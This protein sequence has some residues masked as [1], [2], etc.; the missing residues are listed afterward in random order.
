MA[1]RFSHLGLFCVVLVALPL[2]AGDIIERMVASVN[3]HLILQSDWD[4]AVCFEALASG[5]PLDQVSQAQREAILDRLIDQELLRQQSFVAELPAPPPEDVR[6]RLDE[7]RARYPGAI[8]TDAWHDLLA[9][10]GLD[11]KQLEARVATELSLMRQVDVRFRP[12]VRLDP[13][14]VETYYRDQFLPKLHAAGA[15]E[16]PLEKVSGEIREILI[17]EK[18][19]ELVSTWLQNLRAESRIRTLAPPSSQTAPSGGQAP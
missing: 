1:F 19:N 5:Q 8:T 6:K 16:V 14:S 13:G 12:S 9:R 4:K 2:C 7:I 3:G 17:Q 15:Q 11:E 18:I 10:Y